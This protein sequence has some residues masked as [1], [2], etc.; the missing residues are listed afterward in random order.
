MSV[1]TNTRI[2]QH[3]LQEPV[4]QSITR[5]SSQITLCTN[6]I[7]VIG[8]LQLRTWSRSQAESRR[9]G[10]QRIRST[11]VLRYLAR[12]SPEVGPQ[13]YLTSTSQ[14]G[15]IPNSEPEV[16]GSRKIIV[17]KEY[18]HFDHSR[19]GRGGHGQERSMTGSLPKDASTVQSNSGLEAYN[20][21]KQS[22]Q[23]HTLFTPLPLL[24]FHS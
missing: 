6:L 1:Y 14:K 11:Y 15:D 23:Q 16:H 22:G 12:P 9:P 3:L 2:G 8:P 24:F 18:F 20:E 4:Q 10:L 21:G 17:K 19:E 5:T 7:L 13:Y